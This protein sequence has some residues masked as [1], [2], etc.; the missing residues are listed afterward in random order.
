[1]FT[2]KKFSLCM[3][4]PSMN[5]YNSLKN[6]YNLIMNL[7]HKLDDFCL[8]FRV[9]LDFLAISKLLLESTFEDR[10]A[11]QTSKIPKKI[12]KTFQLSRLVQA[13]QKVVKYCCSYFYETIL[14]RSNKKRTVG[15]YI[16]VAQWGE[17]L[18]KSTPWV[19]FKYSSTERFHTIFF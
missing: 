7:A 16:V 14:K 8:I 18:K 1:M 12:S 15:V 9:K 5:V 10:H 3:L 2:R 17:T 13:S 11:L 19:S 6:S 4:A